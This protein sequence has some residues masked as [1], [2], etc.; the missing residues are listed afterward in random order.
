VKEIVSYMKVRMAGLALGCAVVFLPFVSCGAV[1]PPEGPVQKKIVAFG[2][3]F[4]Q[5]STI[6]N[7]LLYA[8]AFDATP[9]DGVGIMLSEIPCSDGLLLSTRHILHDRPWKYSEVSHLV[10]QL[11]KL[12]AH[13]SMRECFIGS[14][15]SPTNRIDWTDDAAWA[16][17]ANNLAVTARLA[18][19]GGLRGLSI[20]HEDYFRQEQY[21]RQ[22][23]EMPFDELAALVRRRGRE[24]FA[25]VF[26]EYPDVTLISFWLLSQNTSYF[27]S[28]DPAAA[29]RSAGDLWP[30]L[31]N[32]IFDV[33]PPG[34][35]F[36]DGD[37]RSYRYEAETHDFVRATHQQRD[38]ALPLVAPENRAKFLSQM[39]PGC[40]IF[41]DMYVNP[42]NSIW[43]RGPV[44]GSRLNHLERNLHEALSAAG[45]YVWFWGQAHTWMPY[46]ERGIRLRGYIQKT[47]WEECLPGLNETI[48]ALRDPEGWGETRLAALKAAGAKPINANPEC[49]DL[50]GGKIPP[51][52]STWQDTLKRRTNGVFRLDTSFGEGDSSSLCAVGVPY[53][54][55]VFPV[56]GLKTGEWLAVE[57]SAKGDIVTGNVG[58]QLKGKWCKGLPGTPIPLGG[59]FGGW[60]HG[61]AFVRVPAGADGFGMTMGVRQKEGEKSWFD[62]VRVYKIKEADSMTTEKENGK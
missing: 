55:F 47:T 2:W 13:R 25:G 43:Y 58:W 38:G 31:M 34:A 32:G 6:S 9:L 27:G 62:N 45:E 29:A 19:E 39:R 51:P 41:L 15:R 20:D 59:D 8:D 24:L 22:S 40:S 16:R 56:R 17:I 30:S 36:I 12:T 61:R 50:K 26:R 3:E 7:L 23:G 28:R 57:L 11:K 52:Y 54:S 1:L 46:W 33:M 48:R 10:P 53:G 14:L 37:E 4:G 44:D 18:K 49:A 5:V 60:K 42:T 21:F 35:K